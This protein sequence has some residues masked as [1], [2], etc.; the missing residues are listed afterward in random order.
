M[1]TTNWGHQGIIIQV[2]CMDGFKDYA[3]LGSKQQGSYRVVKITPGA[4]IL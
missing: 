1:Y 2:N 4:C 3:V